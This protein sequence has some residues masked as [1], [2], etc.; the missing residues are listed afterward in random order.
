MAA[1]AEM[2]EF[3]GKVA[4]VPLEKFWDPELEELHCRWA[5]VKDKSRELKNSKL[6]KDEQKAA[7]DAYIK[8]VYTPDEWK[9][10]EIGVS[11]AVYH[12]LG[13]AKIMSRIGK[14][15]AE[16]MIKLE[17]GKP[18]N[19]TYLVD[20]INGNDTNPFGKP[21]KTFGKLNSI[22][23]APGD[24]VVIAPGLQ[25]ET[26]KPVGGGTAEKPVVIQFLP[27]VHTIGIRNVK[28]SPMFVSNSMDSDA[29]KPV[30]V[31]VQDFRHLLFEGGG[32]DGDGKTTILYDGRMVQVCNDHSENITFTGLVFD[33]KR[34]TVSEFRVIET[35]PAQAVIQIAEGSDYAIENGKFLWRG[36]WG[37]GA[38]CQKLDLMKGRCRRFRTPRGWGAQG[39]L[40]A[41]ARELGGRKVR[42]DYPGGES[43]LEP[44]HQYHFRNT[45]RD[46]VGVHNTRCKDIVF[47][48]CDFYALT[49]MGFVSQFTENIT[50]HRVNVAPPRDTI[51]T[52]PAWADIFQFSNCKGDILVDSCRL[53]GMQDDA[54]NCHG[55]YLNIIEKT[56]S[57]QLLV[58]FMHRQTYGFP[59]FVPGD[60]IAVICA[61]KLREYADNPRRKVTTLERKSDR[62]WILTLD[63]AVPRFQDKDVVDNRSWHPN[64]TVR[65]NH[66]SVAPVS[67]LLLTTPGKAIV[68]NNV[69]CRCNAYAISMSAD[70][71][72]WFESAPVRDVLIRGNRFIECG[73]S[74]NPALDAINPEEPIHEN[75]RITGNDF[76]RAGINAKG[77]MNLTIIGNTFVGG[78][79]AI[80]IEQSCT[81]I[82]VEKNEQK[83]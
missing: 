42:L 65:N 37:P 22:K 72:K 3:K 63:G 27:G 29:P 38:F 56:G 47:R 59:A 32:V 18:G 58:R 5:K 17:D 76:V 71:L 14:A 75:I 74:V 53:S 28:R 9:V 4:A 78:P 66:F 12:Y 26:L 24:K 11:N 40:A 10:M 44:G 39:Q 16:A 13:S 77:A 25:E 45:T 67:G 68:E 34:P 64:I 54:I 1:P 30:G 46:S 49:G 41:T 7:I 43:G 73:V 82:K 2:P 60:E 61:P 35:S 51:R 48:N 69:F 83:K 15:F 33:L 36:D 21:W 79:L 23:L 20:P 55:T 62:D 50:L 19:T 6:G 81:D 52:C 80:E 8:T 31:L 70:S 57:N